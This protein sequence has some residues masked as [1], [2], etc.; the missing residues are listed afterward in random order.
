MSMSCGQNGPIEGGTINSSTIVGSTIQGSVISGSVIKASAL[1]EITSVDE[2]SALIIADAMSKL[3]TEQLRAL[4]KA[5]A[6]AMPLLSPTVGPVSTN[7]TS[8]PTE[9]VGSREKLL[10]NPNGWLTLR[11]VAVPAYASRE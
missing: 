11:G 6:D 3:S 2:K 10:G 5:I 9:V 7:A 8:L 4:A 1:E